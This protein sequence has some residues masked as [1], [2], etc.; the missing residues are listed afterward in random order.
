MKKSI[1]I[2][3][4]LIMTGT[5]LACS[6][7]KANV[8]E[9]T[10][11]LMEETTS[12]PEKTALPET[13]PNADV[14][15]PLTQELTETNVVLSED[16]VPTKYMNATGIVDE[17]LGI[18]I[19][20]D[21]TE[22]NR[23]GFQGN[24]YYGSENEYKKISFTCY[25]YDG[26]I[27]SYIAENMG[28]E[29]RT[30][31]NME[32]ATLDDSNEGFSE[33]TFVNNGILLNLSMSEDEMQQM[34]KNGLNIY[35]LKETEYLVY[36][37]E[38]AVYFPSLGLQISGK[39]GHWDENIFEYNSVIIQGHNS[40]GGISIYTN[41]NKDVFLDS[42]DPIAIIDN[43]YNG[44]DVDLEGP[45]EKSFGKYQFIGKG[46]TLDYVRKDWFFASSETP[47]LIKIDCNETSTI[48]NYI[49]LIEE[50]K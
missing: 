11:I 17:E 18:V 21:N 5:L 1:V 22:L 16:I 24:A 4:T 2:M 12:T 37:L 29:K 10:A 7:P 28:M 49:S 33:V 15:V 40:D 46:C 36:M 35:E 32:Y 8:Q 48:E 30:L 38:D 43:W 23:I 27:D 42:T 3:I 19:K 25:Y 14:D 47:Y 26:N 31:D 44:L 20:P 45:I 41:S 39:Y 34:W 6:T 9:P 13:P 50:I